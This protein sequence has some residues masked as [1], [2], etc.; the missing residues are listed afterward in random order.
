MVKYKNFYLEFHNE[1][2]L[3]NIKTSYFE[4]LLFRLT[5]ITIINYY[6]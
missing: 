6:R 1:Q 5:Q 3:T 2:I 4:Y